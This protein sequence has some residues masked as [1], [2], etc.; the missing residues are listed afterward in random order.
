MLPR[1]FLT[2][3]I[4]ARVAEA[5]RRLQARIWRPLDGESARIRVE[6]TRSFP[7]PEDFLTAEQAAGVDYAPVP[8]VLRAGGAGFPPVPP[9][10]PVPPSPPSPSSPSPV[11]SA[12][13]SFL[14]CGDLS[15][16]LTGKFIFP[17]TPAGADVDIDT[18]FTGDG[19]QI[20][21]PVESGDKSPHSK[22]NAGATAGVT[23]AATTAATAG[24]DAGAGEFHWGPKYA[25]RW[26]R[27]ALPAPPAGDTRTRWLEWRDQAEA[28]LYLDGVPYSGLDLAHKYCP[29]PAGGTSGTGT[30]SGAGGTGSGGGAGIIAGGTTGPIAGGTGGGVATGI[31]A[32]TI[33]GG[34]ITGGTITGGTGT[35]GGCITGG[36]AA[37]AREVLIEAVCIRSAVWLDG[38]PSP[39][40]ERGSRFAPPRLWTRDDLAWDAWNDLR[41]LL[42]VLEA[43][44]RDFQ[45]P[46]SVGPPPKGF[47]DLVR[48]TPPVFRASPLFRRWCRLLDRAVDVLDRDG[49]PAFSA[50]LKKIYRDFPAEP[51]ALR[52]VLTGHAH[53]D[54]V[55]LWPERVGEFK[56]V[57]T[58][59]TQTRL[60]R[61]YPEFRFGHSQ[62]AGYEAVRR[63]A[64]ALHGRVR[65]LIAAGRWE[66]T[67]AGYVECDTQLPCGEALL[68][69][70]RIGQREFAALRGGGRARVFWLPDVFG[71]SGCM[72][73]LL[74]GT[75]V[76]GFFTSKLSWSTVNRFPHTSFRWRGADG[77]E[78]AAH[79]VLL[80]DYN[81]AVDIRR[82]REDALHHQQAAVH[83]E[84]LVPTGYGDGGGGPTEEML[85][86]ARRVRDLAGAP[87]AGWG[88]I[89]AFFD[90]LLA[91]RE[92]L[93][94]VT[95]EL[96]LELH[97]GVFTT[98]GR[99]KAA[100]RALERA[101]Q[102][103]EAAHAAAGAGPVDGRAWRRLVFSQFHDH[104]TGSSIWEVYAR[105]VPE[106][107]GLAA[108]ALRGAAAVLGGAA[109][110]ALVY[111]ENK[112]GDDGDGGDGG[113]APGWFNP[114]AVTR[115]WTD[116][117]RCY[118]LPP[119]SGAPVGR[120]KRVAADAPRAGAGFLENERV[121]AE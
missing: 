3:L 61:E 92:E 38:T 76:E 9:V 99:L 51:G 105:A 48:F 113:G 95:G 10:P 44:H 109:E 60:L 86:R 43:E 47:A 66:A 112:Y 89:E 88:G 17:P 40:D 73:Q 5:A 77:S 12:P 56:T 39:L 97:R 115:L 49:L 100:F 25:Q 91:V 119:L 84:F 19:G 98:H 58:W 111:P 102:I 27:L 62:P 53:I 80:H 42:D 79:V 63:H 29:L 26:F 70:L 101:L 50:E 117:G 114:L 116:G 18:P 34:T 1:T 31:T 20:N 71:Y 55:W 68:R 11:P 32:D 15:P 110:E 2:Q 59:A 78:V 90:R 64:P 83:P 41:V 6:M 57:H 54:L 103:Q 96:L 120:L 16:L 121:R 4:P 45:P 23:A 22:N 24:A 82:L 35:G 37:A 72:P 13:A 52:A 28:T 81:E 107:E 74:R 104:I 30:D 94:A 8:V 21:L 33:T 93:P 14:E 36:T 106:L 75:G 46:A 7:A 85:E 87:R 108:E 65:G 67:G 118:E 69:G